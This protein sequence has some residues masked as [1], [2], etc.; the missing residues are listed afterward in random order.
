MNSTFFSNPINRKTKIIIWF[1]AL[2]LS[3]V[4]LTFTACNKDALHNLPQSE[5][6]LTTNSITIEDA[7][8]FYY[9]YFKEN[10]ES[11]EPTLSVRNDEDYTSL[12]PDW[13]ISKSHN[14][15]DILG[16]FVTVPTSLVV[17]KG[18]GYRKVMFAK[19]N[20]KVVGIVATINTNPNYVVSK[21][22]KVERKDFTGKI[23]FQKL[24]KKIIG[25][26]EY[27]NGQII[28]YLTPNE[29]S[30]IEPDDIAWSMTGATFTTTASGGSSGFNYNA[31]QF[32]INTGLPCALCGYNNNGTSNSG[33][34]TVDPLVDQNLNN[35]IVN[36]EVLFGV[37]CSSFMFQSGKPGQASNWQEA[38]VVGLSISFYYP[39]LEVTKLF[40]LTFT[41]GTPKQ[42]ASG[43][44][45]SA[46][47]AADQCATAADFALHKTAQYI[48]SGAG[49][50]T[51]ASVQS[52][53]VKN[54]QSTLSFNLPGSR[55]QSGNQ[56]TSG[57]LSYPAVQYGLLDIQ[58]YFGCE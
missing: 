26:V 49:L 46:G 12:K 53:F 29:S 24:N 40:N 1:S 19:V 14:F 22:G 6:N 38:V 16:N 47:Y 50:K 41:I 56:A 43:S 7:K 30:S 20:N 57:V 8:E 36:T 4:L 18:L 28:N 35:Q 23:Y 2:S 33:G 34:T 55:V 54:L 17:S 27:Q 9:N 15:S 21:K 37:H 5:E 58:G 25:G 13:S 31:Y 52:E 44:N 42:L 51:S 3:M 48:A 11:K 45:I 10:P 39:V 32:F